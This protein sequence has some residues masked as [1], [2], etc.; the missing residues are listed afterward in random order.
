MKLLVLLLLLAGGA[1]HAAP[2]VEDV[3][4]YRALVEQDLRLATVG[5]RLASANAP[6]CKRRAPNPGW[7]IHDIA[8]YPDQA[9]AQAAFGFDQPIQIAATVKGAPADNAGL[10]AG[11][12]F[13]ALDDAALRWAAMPVGKT[14]YER[15]AAFRQSLGERWAGRAALL[16]RASRDGAEVNAIIKATPICASEFWVDARPKTDAGADGDQVRLTS[17]MMA[18]VSD[19]AELAAVVAH[20]LAHNL[21][22]HRAILAGVKKGKSKAILKTEIEAD[23]LSVWLM[24]NSGYDANAAVRFWQRYGPKTSLGIFSEGTHLRWKNRVKVLQAEISRMNQAEKQGGLLT[25]PLLTSGG[26][27]TG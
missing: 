25:P 2:K 17:G 3:A 21:L 13:V 5:Y 7:V 20:E 24:A 11:D 15:M 23:Q 26:L 14:G 16:V 10:K 9:T 27:V 18:F 19:D 4:A 8:Q 12:D 6:F 1:A 22:G